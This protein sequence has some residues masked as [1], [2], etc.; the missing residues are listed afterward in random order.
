M[1]F[2]LEIWVYPLHNFSM[3]FGDCFCTC[4]LRM[5][6]WMVACILQFI[7]ME[8]SIKILMLSGKER[9]FGGFSG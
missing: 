2:L 3:V 9:K 1:G 8:L 6:G 7:I 4:V 5:H